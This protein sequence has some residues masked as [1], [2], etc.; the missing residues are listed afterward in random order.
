MIAQLARRTPAPLLGLGAAPPFRGAIVGS[1]FR[2][3]PTRLKAGNTQDFVA[4]WNVTDGDGET[5]ETWHV[6]VE[7]GRCRTAR[8][9]DGANPR[10]TFTITAADLIVLASGAAKPM[11]MFQSSRIKITGDLFFAA[12]MQNMFRIPA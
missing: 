3:M 1:I 6:I 12:Q 9:H 2:L 5:V 10:T 7:N 4:R 11:E 8:H